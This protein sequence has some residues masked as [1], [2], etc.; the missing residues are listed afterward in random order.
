MKS[1]R[2]VLFSSFSLWVVGAAFCLYYL[3]PLVIPGKAKPIKFGIDL[4]GGTYISLIVDTDKAVEDALFGRLQSLKI[5][6]KQEGLAASEKTKIEKNELVVTFATA[7]EARQAALFVREDDAQLNLSQAGAT[8]RLSLKLQEETALKRWAVESN[9]HV[10]RNRLDKFSVSEITIAAQGEKNIIIELPDVDDP[11]KAKAMIGKAAMLEIAVV[12]AEG[13]SEEDILE[14]Y[15]D[16]LPDGFRIVPGK[17]KRGHEESRRYYLM[18]THTEI[19]GKLLK[20]AHPEFG[21]YGNMV[22]AFEFSNEGGKRFYDLTRQN[23][24]RLLAVMLD[25]EVI[26]AAVI[27]EPIGSKGQISSDHFT[28]ESAKELA[29]LLKSGAY[30]APVHFDEERTVGPALGAQAIKQGALSCIVGLVLL[31]FFCV[32]YYKIP[33][34]FAFITL[35]YNLL[36]TLVIFGY[37]GGTLTL[38]GIAGLVLTLGMAIDASILIFEKIKEEL[39]KGVTLKSAIDAGFAGSLVVILDANITHFIMDVVLYKFGTGPVQGF[40]LTMIVG[41][42]T[43]LI[44]G[45]FFLRTLLN[46]VLSF[47]VKK[48]RF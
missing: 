16:E 38:P 22:V 4:V 7:D 39:T 21:Q 37:F 14:K 2:G 23:V 33:G 18:P 34:F 10:L 32:I 27:N 8:I 1:A 43:T 5:G 17:T 25:N 13:M 31:F 20:D 28:P 19:T 36:L 11:E 12:E 9:I 24:S 48:M 46:F 41:I 42:I 45:L 29:D 44:T 26:S 3:S 47:G 40:A 6:L 35:V 15:D 30:V